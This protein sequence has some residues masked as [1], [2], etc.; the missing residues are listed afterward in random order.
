MH[1]YG[2]VKTCVVISGRVKLRFTINNV[3]PTHSLH[4]RSVDLN[5]YITIWMNSCSKTRHAT[6]H[7]IHRKCLAESTFQDMYIVEKYINLLKN[8]TFGTYNLIV[9]MY[10]I[11]DGKNGAEN[12][13]SIIFML[14]NGAGSQHDLCFEYLIILMYN[15]DLIIYLDGA[16]LINKKASLMRILYFEYFITY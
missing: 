4:I 7:I 9:L 2:V 14:R 3:T 5:S 1:G 8:M 11:C 13:N 15:I 6:D 12:K 10:L 16:K